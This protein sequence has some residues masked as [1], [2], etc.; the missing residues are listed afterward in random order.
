M[1]VIH[2]PPFSDAGVRPRGS[3]R[4][5]PLLAPSP[6]KHL[7]SPLPTE[8]G[9]AEGLPVKAVLVGVDAAAVVAAMVVAFGL[10]SMLP[11]NDIVDAHSHHLL[12][13]TL[14]LPLWLGLF[15]RYGLYRANKV[16]DRR[17]ELRR[18][19]H[20]VGASVAAMALVAFV[21]AL[22]VARG[23][24]VLTFVVGVLIV[25]AERE[26]VRRILTGLRRRGR[27]L[28]RVLVVGGNADAE[29]LCSTLAADPALGYHVVGHVA[30]VPT[31]TPL[32]G[33][34]PVMGSVSETLPIARRT[35]V[36]GS[37]SSSPPWGRRLPTDWLV[38]C[39]RPAS[40]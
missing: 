3:P 4:A 10:R 16:A 32:A 17:A 1:D 40:T 31:S 13:G 24:L 18:V 30:D 19:V 6:D 35:G 20:A 21:A 37:S 33:L 12:V 39:P 11:G 29:V 25:S 38:S 7:R 2:T 28:R 14:S 15:A 26:V 34:P 8:A 9:R 27:L 5:V 22:H 36:G 23:W